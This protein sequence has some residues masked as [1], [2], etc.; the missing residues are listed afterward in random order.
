MVGLADADRLAPG[1][2]PDIL[3]ETNMDETFNVVA[4][5]AT[6]TRR[7]R[8]GD[9]ITAAEFDG[10]MSV[11]DALRLKLIERPKPVRSPPPASADAE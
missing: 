10:Q 8:A 3:P 6:R 1:L 5:F 4:P 9:I 7:L 2:I 11:E